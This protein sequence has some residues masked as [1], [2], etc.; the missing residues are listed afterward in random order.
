M[1][2]SM[3]GAL[4]LLFP[5][6][7]SQEKDMG[8]DVAEA[9]KDAMD[10]W[11]K[12]EK[13]SGV[14]LRNIY[15]DGDAKEMSETRYLQPAL[16]VVNMT[17]WMEAASY[18]APKKPCVSGHSL[19]EFSALAAAQVL[20]ME[21]VL[22]CVA[23]RGR[24]MSEA[25]PDGKG[26]MA[27]VVKL[28]QGDVEE[29]VAQAADKS[30]QTLVVANYNS[31]AQYVISGAADAVAAAAPLAKERK[32]RCIPLPVSGAFHSPLIAEAGRELAKYMDGLNWNK[33]QL[34]V[35][36]NATATTEEDAGAIKSIMSGQ[37]TSSVRWIEIISAQ[38][39]AGVRNWFEIG[40]KN[41][42]TKLLKANL[43]SKEGDWAGE[44]LSSLEAVSAKK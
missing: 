20:S 15:W 33:P 22:E 23:L 36:F 5:G 40:P 11:K 27:A 28:Q 3:N 6:Q 34:P 25:D 39:D 16:T 41:V 38:W 29:I 44:S 21:Q 42:L 37:M 10:L 13:I 12:A 19:G 7:G 8:R 9:N 1:S 2:E 4:G 14:E 32:G 30:G 31:P 43:A 17:L 35:F 26:A 24:L 18:F